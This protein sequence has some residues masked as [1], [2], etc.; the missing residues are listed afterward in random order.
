MRPVSQSYPPRHA[1]RSSSG[2]PGLDEVLDGGFI[3]NRVYLIEGNPGAGKTTLALQF[4]LEGLERGER[5]LFISLGETAEELNANAASHGWSLDGIE[6]VEII[7]SEGELDGSNALT[8]YS[9][10]EIELT[11]TMQRL[12]AEVDRV[13]PQRL[14]LDSLAELRLQA[15]DSFRYRRQVMALKQHLTRRPCTVLLLDDRTIDAT[16]L[17]LQSIVHGV[18]ALMQTVPRYGPAQRQLQVSKL[19]GSDFRSGPQ[20]LVIRHGGLSVFPRL[21]AA[22][23]LT[24]FRREVVPSGVASLDTLLGGGIDRGTATLLVGPPGSGKSTIA[25]QYAAAAARRGDH[26]AIFLFEESRGILLNRAQSLNIP[27]VQGT[28]PGEIA[29]RQIEAGGVLPAEFAAMVRT[30]VERDGARIVVLDSLNGY[31]N[32]MPE[33]RALEIQLHELLSYLNNHGVAT[34]L[35]AAQSGVL[36]GGV[37]SPIDTSYLAD[38]V[39]LL[40]MFE[41]EGNVRKAISVLKKRSGRH[42]ESIRHLY[43]DEAGMHLSEPLTMLRGVMSGVPVEMNPIRTAPL[44][45]PDGA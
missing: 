20:D 43:F 37:R 38:T 42:E 32:A 36:G 26:A 30:S 44:R 31:L 24:T 17:Q 25:L 19:R 2:V 35:I 41:H 18:I 34:F 10:A 29:V 9:P 8:M 6:I 7:G 3:A 1:Q 14:V 15:Q 22:D 21:K 12:L 5:G 39:V 16:D 13:K 4:L 45:M 11:D 27:V 40:R 23:H 33:E 28:G